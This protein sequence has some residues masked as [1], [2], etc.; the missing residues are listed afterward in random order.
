VKGAYVDNGG[1]EGRES[2]AEQ[3]SGI[4]LKQNWKTNMIDIIINKRIDPDI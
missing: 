4:S 3:C 2:I 1:D